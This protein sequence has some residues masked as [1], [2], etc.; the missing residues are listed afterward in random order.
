MKADAEKN[1]T[2]V[3]LKT[4]YLTADYNRN[5]TLVRKFYYYVFFLELS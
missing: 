3:E 5:V 1:K 2:I 4:S